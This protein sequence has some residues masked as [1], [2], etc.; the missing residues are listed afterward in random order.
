SLIVYQGPNAGQTTPG[1]GPYDL[2]NAIVSDDRAQVVSVS[3]GQCEQLQ[4]TSEAEAESTLFEEA[5]IQGQ[6]I[7]AATGDEGSEDCNQTAGVPDPQLAVDDPGSQPF[8]TGVGG[9]T[10][11]SLGP[12][13]SE[14]VWNNGG[15]PTTLLATQGGA[16]GGGVSQIWKMPGYQS[17]TPGALHV[18]Q[19][20]SSSSSCGAVSG[21]CRQVPDIAA[22]ADPNTGYLV[23]WNG[24]GSVIGAPSGWQAVGGTSAASPLW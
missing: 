5:A 4:G 11:S 1:S 9:T 18:I 2:F 13:P 22:D 16:G 14:S 19:G 6:S 20:S 17:G 15:N 8:V 10:L 21:Y 24:S 12:P 23:Y 3:W 7:V